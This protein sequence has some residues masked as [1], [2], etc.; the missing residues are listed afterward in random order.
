MVYGVECASEWPKGN[1]GH[2]A[3]D[4]CHRADVPANRLVVNNNPFRTVF[5]ISDANRS[6]VSSHEVV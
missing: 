3:G 4:R 6:T 1:V 5:R 2:S